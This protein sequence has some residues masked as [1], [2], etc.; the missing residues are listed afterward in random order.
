MISQSR[1]RP[2]LGEDPPLGLLAGG[3]RGDG[4]PGVRG[5]AAAR[6]GVL[7]P[8]RE[9]LQ[10]SGAGG[11]RQP[12]HGLPSLPLHLVR[13]QHGNTQLLSLYFTIVQLCFLSFVL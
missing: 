11:Q 8:G 7:P 12:R 13:L 5:A 6:A 9:G 3:A 2:Q 10:V 4:G 1:R